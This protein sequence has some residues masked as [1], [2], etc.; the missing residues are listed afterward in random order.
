MAAAPAT[1]ACAGTSVIMAWERV[2]G[3][4]R[5]VAALRAAVGGERVAQAYLF[6][7]PDG[8]GKRAAAL[9]LAQ[10]LLCERRGADGVST[11]DACGTCSSCSRASRLI[12]PDL[13][14]LF[15]RPKD[16]EPS[17]IAARLAMLAEDPYRAVDYRRLPSLDTGRAGRNKQAIYNKELIN[18]DLRRALSLRPVEG[19]VTVAVLTDADAMNDV[20][21]NSFLRLLEEPRPHVKLVLTVE[22]PDSL[23]PTILSRCQRARFDPLSPEQ[24]E[25]ALVQRA[26]A[27]QG[28]A[29]VVARLA[30]GSY[31]RAQ[32]ILEGEDLQ[33][34]RERALEFVRAA[35]TLRPSDVP[36]VIES[37]AAMGREPLKGLLSQLSGWVRDLVLARSMGSEAPLV[38]VDQAEPIRKFLER[39]P[40]A[41]LGEM[42]QHVEEASEMLERNVHAV[43]LLSTLAHA[44]HDAMLGRPRPHLHAPLTG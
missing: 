5:T 13:H 17:D 26:G 35:Y 40:A 14:F 36:A 19:G 15:P 9:A 8:A 2:I 7:G 6:H 23:L 20:A 42:A 39:A 32:A 41:R 16:T 18:E 1:L 21:A 38:N 3:Q 31:T 43:L 10:T 11:D 37:T 22:R 25:E 33:D 12:H 4:E 44:L 34:L 24:I 28:R 29:A 30:D 27:E